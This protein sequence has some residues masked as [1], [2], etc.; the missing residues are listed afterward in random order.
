MLDTNDSGASSALHMPDTTV[1][2]REV[3][4]LDIDLQVPA[5]SER[6]ERVPDFDAS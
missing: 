4:G 6:T 1:S 2:V 5:Y 3:F